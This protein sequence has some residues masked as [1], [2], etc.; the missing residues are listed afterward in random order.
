MFIIDD[1][2][3][4]SHQRLHYQCLD[5]IE[6]VTNLL[7]AIFADQILLEK[8]KEPFATFF[9]VV[10]VASLLDSNI[11]QMYEL[12]VNVIIIITMMGEPCKPI[13][14]Q[15]HDQRLIAHY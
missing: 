7:G 1:D 9:I 5:A 4:D 11:S 15:I 14:I 3:L 12:I 13:P 2:F 8:I 6:T 10:I